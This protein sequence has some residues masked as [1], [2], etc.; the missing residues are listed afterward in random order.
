MAAQPVEHDHHQNNADKKSGHGAAN[1][2]CWGRRKTISLIDRLFDWL[3]EVDW[4]IE[5]K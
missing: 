5:V 1:D 2:N 3:I 4:S